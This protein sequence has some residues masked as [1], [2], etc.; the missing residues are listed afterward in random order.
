MSTPARVVIADDHGPLR[1]LL[2]E[3]LEDAGFVICAEAA[4]SAGAVDAALEHRPE[5]CVLDVRMPPEGG[6]AATASIRDRLPTTE[7]VLLSGHVDPG[8]RAAASA[9]GAFVLLSKSAPSEAI[10][11]AIRQ[12]AA[13]GIQT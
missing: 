12:A 9:A 2:R 10:V 6:I 3:E 4:D 8:V 1:A 5:V 13:A 11:A 7:V